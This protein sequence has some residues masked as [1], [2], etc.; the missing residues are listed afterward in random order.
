MITSVFLKMFLK[1]NLKHSFLHNRTDQ[2]VLFYSF[3]VAFRFDKDLHVSQFAEITIL[4][5]V[6]VCSKQMQIASEKTT[7][8][9][10]SETLTCG[11]KVQC[12]NH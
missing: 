4:M 8:H 3:F 5:Y 2:G 11:S 12:F 10:F 1:L 7:T 9:A 6:F